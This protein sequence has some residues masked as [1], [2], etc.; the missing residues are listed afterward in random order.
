MES[1]APSAP[2]PESLS[3]IQDFS[4]QTALQ[5]IAVEFII[6]SHRIN[7]EVRH[8]GAP[9]R[10]VDYLNSIDG[11]RVAIYNCAV[12]QRD[13]PAS[14]GQF[15]DAQIHRNAIIMAIPRGNTTFTINSLEVVQ[16]RPVPAVLVMPGYDVSGNIYMVAQID[17]T[18]TPL[19]GNHNF[20]PVTDA[21]ITPAGDPDGAWQE[22]L[23]VINMTRC[24]VY[25]PK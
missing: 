18:N 15:N 7:A 1:E 6:D 12:G 3:E 11:P 16:K 2:P 5:V 10:L 13:D 21:T 4:V 23:L 24:L 20:L 22:R 17:P 25:V 9:R 14:V 8:P 19:I